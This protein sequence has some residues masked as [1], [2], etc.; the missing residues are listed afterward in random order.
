MNKEQLISQLAQDTEVSKKV[1][2]SVLESL[3]RAIQGCLKNDGGI[4]I[5]GLGTFVVSDRKAR[6]GVNPCTQEKIKIP[7]TKVPS[8]RAAKALKEVV[9]P[10]EKPAAK[11]ASKKS[12]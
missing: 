7:A 4:R 10:Q 11:K 2:K 8:F 3:V 9:K 5:D 12:R 6:T 1:A